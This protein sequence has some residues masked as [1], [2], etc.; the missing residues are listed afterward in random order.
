MPSG[1]RCEHAQYVTSLKIYFRPRFTDIKVTIGWIGFRHHNWVNHWTGDDF[2]TMQDLF[3]LCMFLYFHAYK[4]LV[5]KK[6]W[7]LRCSNSLI[8][9]E[10][11]CFKKVSYLGTAKRCLGKYAF[12]TVSSFMLLLEKERGNIISNLLFCKG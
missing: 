5:S 11:F 8:S 4:K 2:N 9:F 10:F 3:L 7:F 12:R 1:G 6:M